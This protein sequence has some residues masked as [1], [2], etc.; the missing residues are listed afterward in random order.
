[1]NIQTEIDSLSEKPSGNAKPF[2]EVVFNLPLREPFT[3]KIPPQLL[4]KVRVGM[5]VLVPFGRRRITGYVVNLTDKWDKPIRLKA[6]V[7]LPDT[8]PIVSAELLSL[9]RWLGE[10]Y[11]SSWGEAISAALP[12]GLDKAGYQLVKSVRLASSLPDEKEIE[13]LL[14]RSPKQKSVFDL[15]RQKEINLPELQT[16]IPKSQAALRSLKEKQLVEVYTEKKVRE[17][18]VPENA[19]TQP[20]GASLTFTP[21]QQA[22]FK[23]LSLAIET[24]KFESFLLHGVTGSGK[25]EIYI[26]C[27]QR[28]LEKGKTAIMMVPEISLTPQTVERFRQRFGDRVAILH[29]GLSQTERYLEWKKIRDEK[30]SIAVG[31]RSA[32]F[33]PFKNLGIVVIDEEHDSSYKQDSNPRY[34]A[35]DTAVMRAQSLNAVVLMGSATPS[36]ESAQNTRRGKYQYLSLENRIGERMLP[37]VSMV[38]MRRERKESCVAQFAIGFPAKNRF[39]CFSIDAERPDLFFALTAV[40]Y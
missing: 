33:A 22:I 27:I 28:V 39:S 14:K 34:H 40:T 12:A 16:R 20:F 3:Y 19:M 17:A 25:T 8:E 30:V 15:I 9:T 32:V 23:K 10:Y 18:F 31:A 4:G 7:E 21:E 24:E 5:R 2:A 29:S 6:I 11:Q 13:R 1:M 37:I 38:D 26:R 36:L 35:R